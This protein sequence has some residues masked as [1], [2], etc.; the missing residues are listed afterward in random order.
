MTP[1]DQ[2]LGRILPAL[3]VA[4]GVTL[5]AA[6]LLSYTAPPASAPSAP[7]TASPTLVAASASP[8]PIPTAARTPSPLAPASRI[9]VPALKIDLPVVSGRLNPPGNVNN[10][11]LCDVAQY[12]TDFRQPGQP[13]TTYIYGHARTG[14]FLPLLEE[15]M[16]DEGL[17]MIGALVQ[18]YT[19]DAWVYLYEIY[20]V[21]RHATDFTLADN[22]KPDEHRLIMQTSEG[23]RGT[24]PKLQVAARL[25]SVQPANPREARP[26]PK[27]RVCV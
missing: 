22:L 7:P 27:P 10:Y 9:V 19:S 26:S 6:G 11:P 18:V 8:T 20:R 24:V 4:A 13:G 17:G 15:S 3:I 12:L 25:L 21:K 5:V 1:R 14:M 23:P 16:Q 2:L